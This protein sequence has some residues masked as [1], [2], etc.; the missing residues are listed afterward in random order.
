[1]VAALFQVAMVLVAIWT[2][3]GAK[4][5]WTSPVFYQLS[6]ASDGAVQEERPVCAWSEAAPTTVFAMFSVRDYQF[7]KEYFKKAISTDAGQSFT[8]SNLFLT[9]AVVPQGM[10][11]TRNPVEN[12]SVVVVWTAD[13]AGYQNIFA[14]RSTDGGAT[15]GSVFTL[16]SD[17]ATD[18]QPEKSPRI[19]TSFDGVFLVVWA[20]G[21]TD[22][23]LYFSRSTDDGS[24][25]SATQILNS[26]AATDGGLG[27]DIPAVACVPRNT[28]RTCIVA[29][30]RANTGLM[31]ARS[32]DQGATWTSPTLVSNVLT[33]ISAV[34]IS[35]GDDSTWL[36]VWYSETQSGVYATRSTNAGISWSGVTQ[37]APT[38]HLPAAQG[39]LSTDGSGLWMLA[40][41]MEDTSISP[42]WDKIYVLESRNNALNWT[43]SYVTSGTLDTF[44]KICNNRKGGWLLSFQYYTTGQDFDIKYMR[45]SS[46]LTM[47]PVVS[48]PTKS[49]SVFPSKAPTR[50]PTKSPSTA[51][52]TASPSTSLPS[53]AP[54]TSPSTSKP[55]QSP[56]TSTPSASP[57][58]SPS[59]STP[60][61]SPSTSPTSSAPTTSPTTS[62]PTTS[63]TTSTPTKS[64]TTSPTTSKP[65][66]SP[67]T[68]KPTQ[69]PTTSPTSSAATRS[70]SASNPTASP[71]TSKPTLS[72]TTTLTPT[73]S[74]TISKPTLSPSTASAHP[75]KSPTTSRPSAAPTG[76]TPFVTRV[77]LS[78]DL[79]KIEVHFDDDTNQRG[80]EL[81]MLYPCSPGLELIANDTGCS[82]ASCP[83]ACSWSSPKLLLVHLNPVSNFVFNSSSEPA[84]DKFISIRGESS[85]IRH[86]FAVSG[87]ASGQ[88][89]IEIDLDSILLP[90][91]SISGPNEIP[92]CGGSN[93]LVLLTTSGVS[94]T[95][96]RIP[97]RYEWFANDVA[98]PLE[99]QSR[100]IIQE[101]PSM[102]TSVRY[103][104]RITSFV[105]LTGWSDEFI[106]NFT[107]TAV[108]QVSLSV[109]AAFSVP[110]NGAIE[111]DSVVHVPSACLPASNNTKYAFTWRVSS[112]SDSSKSVIL[113]ESQLIVNPAASLFPLLGDSPYRVDLEVDPV[114]LVGV[115]KGKASTV[116]TVVRVPIV[117]ALSTPSRLSVD[118]GSPTA[119]TL[120]ASPSCDP[121]RPEPFCHPVSGQ[122]A[123]NFTGLTF[124][125]FCESARKKQD[126][127]GLCSSVA[128]A[129]CVVSPA[130]MDVKDSPYTF[131]ANVSSE[132]DSK[133]TPLIQI[134][135]VRAD[136]QCPSRLP[137]VVM[138]P[139]PAKINSGEIGEV[140][141]RSWVE[142][143]D[144][145]P[146]NGRNYRWQQV[147]ASFGEGETLQD[148]PTGLTSSSDTNQPNL[149]LQLSSLQ[150]ATSYRFRLIATHPCTKHSGDA[151]AEVSFVTNSPPFPGVVAIVPMTARALLD[152]FTLIVDGAVDDDLPLQFSFESRKVQNNS[153]SST[154]TA[155]SA[156]S[157]SPQI[158]TRFAQADRIQVVARV[159][160]SLQAV[161]STAIIDNVVAYTDAATVM[162]DVE[163]EME[164][165]RSSGG[166]S[167]DILRAVS[168]MAPLVEDDD[169]RMLLLEWIA[170]T[171]RNKPDPSFIMLQTT[172]LSVLLAVTKSPTIGQGFLDRASALVDRLLD[173]FKKAIVDKA[174]GNK[175]DPL[176]SQ[177]RPPSLGEVTVTAL[178]DILTAMIRGGAE[179]VSTPPG[180]GG[181]RRLLSQ[182][183]AG[184]DSLRLQVRKLAEVMLLGAVP[185]YSPQ[186][187]GDDAMKIVV[188]VLDASTE[189]ADSLPSK[190]VVP[191][192]NEGDG[193]VVFSIGLEDPAQL[194]A[195]RFQPSLLLSSEMMVD[196]RLVSDLFAL[197]AQINS[198]QPPLNLTGTIKI[199]IPFNDSND[200]STLVCGR[201]TDSGGIFVWSSLGCSVSDH[202]QTAGWATCECSHQPQAS[203]SS[204]YAMWQVPIPPEDASDNIVPLVVGIVVAVTVVV[205]L[206]AVMV[207]F[208]KRQQRAAGNGLAF[209]TAHGEENQAISV[210]VKS[211]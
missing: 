28:S 93:R 92:L 14:V 50:L 70:P 121:N 85:N 5:A 210:D 39:D 129:D 177:Y 153:S 69:S 62:K 119:V 211:V 208:R 198:T 139:F 204:L 76:H 4:A 143:F 133:L 78:P 17:A 25:W 185:G 67:T 26:D 134:V 81:L 34:H 35:V 12:G 165:I 140:A 3:T 189:N 122:T 59:T 120:S 90:S 169:Q 94:G 36:I 202:N 79:T 127:S 55:T 29:W 106:V 51:R 190:I 109:P 200:D 136:S 46:P 95:G 72:P 123:R 31:V 38:T 107:S 163:K 1:M 162:N 172:A 196:G 205:I 116:V 164:S 52:P 10:V 74:P 47:A 150:P 65:T 41:S 19:A 61:K 23:E 207:V 75:T 131:I 183:L 43:G 33:T 137:K 88:F 40:L 117:A 84:N 144:F 32:N 206:I 173:D 99:T 11:G 175:N 100:L 161:S 170:E 45:Q 147:L 192:L 97:T 105:G 73:T 141:I 152:D 156:F 44:P 91:V 126:C 15:V 71:T 7:S 166:S 22:R 16:N 89:P 8:V 124:R 98:I 193:L 101:R 142:D 155:L 187:I 57:S 77:L 54:T 149:V 146:V 191:R 195:Y 135:V 113:N 167:E 42:P 197:D 110:A 104:L 181:R 132:T 158:Q 64:P 13:T 203:S 151:F 108:A 154:F 157:N 128:N 115:R 171:S 184:F 102:E 148:V 24:T 145:S 112:L 80:S 66:T 180:K 201:S 111:I 118:P 182:S 20:R 160:D 194:I 83:I 138:M 30:A 87:S 21:T 125:W 103:R 86:A 37:I 6:M 209:P 49:P 18:G 48:A 199:R 60:T 188:A 56:I 176:L 96:N 114:G 2:G 179:A 82:I 53:K 174:N 186:V 159:R 63:P 27:D 130:E 9:P 58:T 68:S 178:E 168:A